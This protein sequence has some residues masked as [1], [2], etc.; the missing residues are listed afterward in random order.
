[1]EER[2]GDISLQVAGPE[3]RLRRLGGSPLT[4][5][6]LGMER[7]RDPGRAWGFLDLR[8]SQDDPEGSQAP[9]F[10]A[11]HPKGMVTGG[12]LLKND[13]GVS[14]NRLWRMERKGKSRGLLGLRMSQDD[15]EISSFFPSTP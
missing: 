10:F 9:P 13:V 1:M 3:G 7:K 4:L 6:S 2:G 14:L 11:I 15:E 12:E 5:A 8:I